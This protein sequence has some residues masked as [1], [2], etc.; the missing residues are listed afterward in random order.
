MLA[1]PL[2]KR[3]TR[4]GN[5]SARILLHAATDFTT[6]KTDTSRKVAALKFGWLQKNL[7]E[8]IVQYLT[9]FLM[10]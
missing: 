8:P 10:A 6:Y 2:S 5:A 1:K 3:V 9:V 7:K 4:P